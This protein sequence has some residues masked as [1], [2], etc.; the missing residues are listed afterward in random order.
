M[1]KYIIN[2]AKL[3]GLGWDGQLAYQWFCSVDAG[4]TYGHAEQ[5]AEAVKSAF[6]SP[7]YRVAL[8][9]RQTIITTVDE[10]CPI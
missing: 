7:E 8:Q 2:I 6:T 5:V 9:E 3:K 1:G 10:F 4:D